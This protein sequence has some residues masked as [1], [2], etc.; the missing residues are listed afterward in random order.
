MKKRNVA[1]VC[2][3]LAIIL[4]IPIPLR[5]KDGG[6]VEYKALAYSVSR[7]HRLAPAKAEK[8]YEEGII[9]K[10]LGIEVYNNVE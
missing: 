2:I 6:T 4:L 7:V 10:V 8:E 9:I 5:L 3:L 1:I